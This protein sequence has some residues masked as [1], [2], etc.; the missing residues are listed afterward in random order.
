MVR[1]SGAPSKEVVQAAARKATFTP[2]AWVELAEK[3]KSDGTLRD[4]V[5]KLDIT[6]ANAVLLR[7][8]KLSMNGRVF[9]PAAKVQKFVVEHQEC[10]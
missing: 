9:A 7:F 4:E 10:T 6:Q 8:T 5:N 2:K 3:L 1:G